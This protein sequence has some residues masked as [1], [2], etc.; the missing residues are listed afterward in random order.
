VSNNATVNGFLSIGGA[1]LA[2][3]GSLRLSAGEQ[4]MWRCGSNDQGIW[5]DSTGTFFLQQGQA[6]A[7]GATAGSVG[8]PTQCRGFLQLNLAGVGLVKI[9]VYNN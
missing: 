3:S 8:K 4:V 5:F 2:Q 7:T 1:G 9:A 6:L